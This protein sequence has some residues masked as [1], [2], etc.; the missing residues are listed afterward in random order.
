LGFGALLLPIDGE[1]TD[2]LRERE[3]GRCLLRG[4]IELLSDV[5]GSSEALLRM[6]AGRPKGTPP[7]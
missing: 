6:D 4:R 7:W 3:S 2:E 5:S 1:K